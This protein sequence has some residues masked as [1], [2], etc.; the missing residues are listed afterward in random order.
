[1]I[2]PVR[3]PHGEGEWGDDN[4]AYMQGRMTDF[5]TAVLQQKS[6]DGYV[7]PETLRDLV[8]SAPPIWP[9]TARLT[10]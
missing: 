9:S 7:E 3:G 10:P 8:G 4:I 1:M 6:V 2:A 5:A